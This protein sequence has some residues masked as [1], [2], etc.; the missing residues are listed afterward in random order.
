MVG[1]RERC[2]R[3]FGDGWEHICLAVSGSEFDFAW[4]PMIAVLRN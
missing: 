2:E 3:S 1:G 4:E